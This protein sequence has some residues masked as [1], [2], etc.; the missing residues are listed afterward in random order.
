M[1][2]RITYRGAMQTIARASFVIAAFGEAKRVVLEVVKIRAGYVIFHNG[3]KLGLGPY[4][5]ERA[6]A[7]ANLREGEGLGPNFVIAQRLTTRPLGGRIVAID[8]LRVVQRGEQYLITQGDQVVAVEPCCYDALE[9]AGLKRGEG[10]LGT[11][12]VSPAANG[13]ERR[14]SAR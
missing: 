13:P 12:D 14:R 2:Q 5:K 4:E 9:Y 11:S 1:G 7:V 10:L 8:W 3:R 6:L